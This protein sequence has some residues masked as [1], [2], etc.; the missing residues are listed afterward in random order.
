MMP[1]PKAIKVVTTAQKARVGALAV[2]WGEA[3]PYHLDEVKNPKGGPSTNRLAQGEKILLAGSVQFEMHDTARKRIW[4]SVAST[5]TN[6][7]HTVEVDYSG[8]VT[9]LNCTCADCNYRAVRFSK[10]SA[11]SKKKALNYARL[12]CKHMLASGLAMGTELAPAPPKP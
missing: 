10:M 11:E 9:I 7:V 2:K 12:R 1:Q 6:E 8:A 3:Q 5:S 4:F